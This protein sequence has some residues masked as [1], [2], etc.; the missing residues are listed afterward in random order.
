VGVEIGKAA[1]LNPI[2]FD[3]DRSN[4]RRDAARELDKLVEVLNDLP[5]VSIELSSH[6]DS[7]ATDRYN[8]ALSQ[9]R[10]NSTTNYLISKGINPSRI[11]AVG[12]GE[13]Q[14]VNDC[15]NGV[16]C[17]EE[18]HAMNR[19][20]EFEITAMGTKDEKASMAEK[21]EAD[22]DAKETMVKTTVTST[23]D[24]NIKAVTGSSLAEKEKRK[25]F[26]ETK[27]INVFCAITDAE[28]GKPISGVEVIASDILD[29]R[30]I[31]TTKTNE[32]GEF[33]LR[34]EDYQMGDKVYLDFLLSKEGYISKTYD[35]RGK[36]TKDFNSF[37]NMNKHFEDIY[38]VAADLDVDI[39][40][41]ANIAT[42][43]FE[44]DQAKISRNSAIE[45]DKIAAILVEQPQLNIE[46]GAHTDSRGDNAYNLKL[47][48]ERAVATMNYLVSRGVSYSRITAKGYGEQKLLNHCADGVECSEQ[49]HG[50]NRRTEFIIR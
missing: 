42:I 49:E 4:I 43:E 33:T 2:Y 26:S 6:T 47:S 45:L 34:I 15:E 11:V 20:T 3:L 36:I 31:Y 44:L 12:Y 19:R 35:Y 48:K 17:P 5:K 50:E 30:N 25:R 29:S 1:N 16:D 32:N 23:K 24:E 9:R 41:A 39:R 10:A 8:M 38:L 27:T 37:V 21:N 22:E 7:R 46:I 13:S 40:K 18:K 14:L 28:S